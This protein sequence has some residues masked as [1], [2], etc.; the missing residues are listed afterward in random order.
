MQVKKQL[1]SLPGRQPHFHVK[2]EDLFPPL[3]F[4]LPAPALRLAG[5]DIARAASVGPSLLGSCFRSRSEIVSWQGKAQSRRGGQHFAS[6]GN[7]GCHPGQL[8]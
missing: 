1:C 2:E 3:S 8:E 6:L 4:T 5:N 7:W